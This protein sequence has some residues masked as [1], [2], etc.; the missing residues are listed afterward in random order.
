MIH[1][2]ANIYM[3]SIYSVNVGISDNFD[4]AFSKLSNSNNFVAGI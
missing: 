2:E 3:V 4:R 1:L